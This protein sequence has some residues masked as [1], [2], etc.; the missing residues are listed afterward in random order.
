MADV[1]LQVNY[2]ADEL[3]PTATVA[4]IRS[5]PSTLAETELPE[6]FLAD[7]VARRLLF[8]RGQARLA[9]LVSGLRLPA[10]VLEELLTLM[11][12]ERTVD[13]ARRGATH[14]D[15]VYSLTDLGRTKASESMSMCRY[16]GPAPVSYQSYVE[17][18]E[19]QSVGRLRITQQQVNAAYQ[20]VVM[21]EELREQVGAALNS[22]R[23]MFFYGPAGSGKTYLA[24]SLLRLLPGLVAIPYAFLIENEIVQVFDPII[25]RPAGTPAAEPKLDLRERPDP[26]WQLCHRPMVVTGGELRLEMLDLRYEPTSGFY[27]APPHVKA[28]NGIF[29]VDDLGRQLVSPEQLMNRWVVPMDRRHDYLSLHTGSTFRLPFDVVLVFATNLSPRDLADEAFLRRLGSKI[30]IGSVDEH[31]YREIFMRVCSELDIAFDEEGLSTTL[32]LHRRMKQPQLA[33]HPRD[34]LGVVRDHAVYRGC[35]PRA[36][37]VA[38]TA[39]WNIHFA[40]D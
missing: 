25:H 23:P 35:V 13:L 24:E 16:T 18:V 8:H 34:L 10:I 39:A 38:V 32:S 30:H 22:A 31:D 11:R 33:C 40:T 21:R 19:L 2:L 7:L 20:G 27:Q 3:V 14:G 12:G 4:P 26:R 36:T 28:N 1:G 17:Q 5:S 6:Q 9:E 15:I 37:A 29:I